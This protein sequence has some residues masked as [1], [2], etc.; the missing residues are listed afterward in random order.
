MNQVY[1]KVAYIG[2]RNADGSYFLNVPLYVK[3]NAL[4]KCGMPEMQEELMHRVSDIMLQH[5]EKEFGEHIGK[6]KKGEIVNAKV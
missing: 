2:L 4:H 1:Q 5:Y 3:V 6:L